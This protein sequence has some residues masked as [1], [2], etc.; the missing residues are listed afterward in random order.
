[1]EDNIIFQIEENE[2][3]SYFSQDYSKESLIKEVLRGKQ[4]LIE[5]KL[6][7]S[8]Y[9]RQIKDYEKEREQIIYKI[10]NGY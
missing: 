2:D 3:Y 4:R 6:E 7:E 5:L 10:V 1:M 8:N 9:K